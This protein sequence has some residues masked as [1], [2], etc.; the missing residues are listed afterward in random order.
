MAGPHQIWKLDLDA[1]QVGVWAGIGHENIDDGPLADR[2]V[3]PAERPGDRRQAPV[4]RRLRGLR[5]PRDHGHRAPSDPT[6]GRI[7]GE[8]LFEFG[9]VDGTGD[10]VRLQHCLGLAYG[11]GKLYIADTYNNKIKVCDPEDPRRSTTF[12]GTGKPGDGDNPPR[13]YQP[14]G[15]SVAGTELYVAD[16]NNHKIRVDRPEDQGRQDARDQRTHPAG[17]GGAVAGSASLSP[18]RAEPRKRRRCRRRS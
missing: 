5:R 12:V 16:T 7:V 8:G 1:G 6:S 14:G 11:D 3:R 13:F 17:T 4:R 9:D 2:P 15:L 18:L 10:E